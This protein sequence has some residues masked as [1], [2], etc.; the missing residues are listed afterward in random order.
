M[1]VIVP[2]MIVLFLLSWLNYST[3]RKVIEQQLELVSAQMGE[4]LLGSLRYEMLNNDRII[5]RRTLGDIISSKTIL[6]AWVINLDGQIKVSSNPAEEGSLDETQKQ[7]CL[8]CH[9]FPADIRPHVTQD[10]KITPGVMRIITPVQNDPQC[11]ECHPASQKHLGILLIDAPTGEVEKKLLE[12]LQKNLLLS[13]LLSMIIGLGVYYIISKLIVARIENL[14]KVLKDYSSGNF[15]IRIPEGQPWNDE[16]MSL[17]RTFNDM[18]ER[19]EQ[20][21]ALLEEH[22]RVR[23]IA[24]VEERERIARELHDGIAQFLGYVI[25]KTKAAS[26]LLKKENYI[27]VDDYLQQI[28]KEAEFQ[29]IDVRSSILGLKLFSGVQQDLASDIRMCLEQTNRFMDLQV[30]AEVAAGLEELVLEPEMELQLL[31]IVQEAVSNIRKHARAKTARV[32]LE[33]VDHG[34][35]RITIADLG[36]GFDKNAI[37]KKGRPNFGLS[38]MRERAEA[39]RGVFEIETA[40]QQGTKIKI[41][42]KL[43]ETKSEN[44]RSR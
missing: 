12:N 11:W 23:E 21:G 25:A 14:D 29:A 27:K 4:I 8:L 9:Q 1:M 42:V 16:I 5:L 31:R 17:G 33:K 20:H 26:L 39:I 32:I 18:A 40:E 24:I 6:R 34:S 15:K 44:I 10:D 3:E 19:L 2:I 41:T 28:E 7:S 35:I 30:T 37:S 36:I 22:T 13:T 38:T 43:P